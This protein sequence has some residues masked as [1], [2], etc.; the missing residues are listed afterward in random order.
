M[1]LLKLE[2]DNPILVPAERLKEVLESNQIYE[3]LG[4]ILDLPELTVLGTI[5]DARG[6]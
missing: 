3:I 1:I 4:E 6:E 2:F 5:F